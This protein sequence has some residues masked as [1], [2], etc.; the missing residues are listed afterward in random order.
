MVKMHSSSTR[1]M[2]KIVVLGASPNPERVSY[3]AVKSLI[4]R[5]YPVIPVGIRSGIIQSL[6][7]VIGKPVIDEVHTLLLYIG[8]A[9]QK[10]YY[11]YIISLKPKRII[12]NPG[13]ENSELINL[14]KENKIE[15]ILDCALVMLGT[16]SF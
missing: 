14:C 8:P 3:K 5:N 1:A 7:I 9:R 4:K 12:F 16:G 2:H 13:T 15:V 10:E 11:D 6:P